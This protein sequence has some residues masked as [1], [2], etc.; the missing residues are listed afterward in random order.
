MTQPDSLFHEVPVHFNCR[1]SVFDH[2]VYVKIR[3]E[4]LSGPSNGGEREKVYR[5]LAR[6]AEV[7]S[8]NADGGKLLA[9]GTANYEEHR[10]LR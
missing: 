2:H 8:S 4:P 5:I 6:Q 1:A 9:W 7:P 3:S 10:S